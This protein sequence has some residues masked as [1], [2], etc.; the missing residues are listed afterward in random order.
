MVPIFFP[1]TYITKKILTASLQLFDKIAI[2]QPSDLAI[3]DHYHSFQ[4]KQQLIIR[5]PLADH[6]D[7]NRLRQEYVYIQNI[8]KDLG[9]DLS[10]IKA[11]PDSPPF[12]DEL[13]VNQ[14]RAQIKDNDQKQANAELQPLLIALF[15]HLVQDTRKQHLEL[16]QQLTDIERS[17]KQLFQMLNDMD[18]YNKPLIS[19]SN[20]NAIKPL[21]LLK[22]WFF[23]HL[24][25][26]EITG[27]FITDQHDVLAEIE[28]WNPDIQLVLRFSR[29]DFDQTTFKPTILERILAYVQGNNDFNTDDLKINNPSNTCFEIY[30]NNGHLSG[31]FMTENAYL[32]DQ[33]GVKNTCIVLI[34]EEG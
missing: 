15:F 12:W 1:S 23:I 21:M 20:S 5:M 28:E 31:P 18:D 9:P 32:S 8:G 14:I 26:K 7:N 27:I 17:E 4:N 3:P 13:S 25:D 16:N 34:N 30:T 10:H 2:Y 19:K 6:L 24:L 11:M 29:S 33:S 22:N